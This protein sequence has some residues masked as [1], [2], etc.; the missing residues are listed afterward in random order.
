MQTPDY[1]QF[2]YVGVGDPN[3]DPHDCVAILSF[4]PKLFLFFHLNF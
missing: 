2:F 4:N 1:T 3:S